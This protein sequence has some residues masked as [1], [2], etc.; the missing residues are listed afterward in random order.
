MAGIVAPFLETANRV[1]SVAVCP[2]EFGPVAVS[3]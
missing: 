1:T 2:S 3:P